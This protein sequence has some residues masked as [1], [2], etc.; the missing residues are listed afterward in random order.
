MQ[1]STSFDVMRTPAAYVGMPTPNRPAPTPEEGQQ[2]V[3]AQQQ[4]ATRTAEAER[5]GRGRML[6]I[7]V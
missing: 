4:E 5:T 3:A 1:M 6:D 7:S 2:A